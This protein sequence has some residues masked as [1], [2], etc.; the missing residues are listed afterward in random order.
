MI[1]QQVEKIVHRSNPGLRSTSEAREASDVKL[2][3]AGV[4]GLHCEV[5][6]N[7]DCSEP[8]VVLSKRLLSVLESGKRG[9]AS[10]GRQA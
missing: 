3:I 8:E 2:E 4:L 6:S 7:T 9:V 1:S 5:A 10:E